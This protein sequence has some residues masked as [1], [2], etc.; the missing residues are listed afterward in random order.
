MRKWL[1]GCFEAVEPVAHQDHGGVNPARHETNA[2]IASRLSG[3]LC[4]PSYSL[5]PLSSLRPMSERKK[6][7]AENHAR[8]VSCVFLAVAGLAFGF[9]PFP[10]TRA[11]AP[12]CLESV[13]IS[14]ATSCTCNGFTCTHSE[15]ITNVPW[16]GFCGNCRWNV[17]WETSCAQGGGA[18]SDQQGSLTVDLDCDPH[19]RSTIH[20]WET[21]PATGADW[22]KINFTCGYCQ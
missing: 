3:E 1:V 16:S 11:Q 10:L 2:M 6:M 22:V 19:R 7:F 13:T 20:V 18:C 17:V 4:D 5:I 15:T 12:I 21:C 14:T 8:S 9:G